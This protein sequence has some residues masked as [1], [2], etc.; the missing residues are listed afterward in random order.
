MLSKVASTKEGAKAAIWK[1]VYIAEAHAIDEWPVRSARFNHGH[2][3]VLV[4]QP[5]R[6][7]ERCDLARN[8]ANDF[9]GTHVEDVLVDDPEL[10]DPFEK[11]YAPWPLRLYLVEK[12]EMRWIAEPRDCSFDDAVSHLMKLLKLD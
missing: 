5:V 7:E 2:G 11:A 1:F 4:Q 6:H 12:G 9:L 10:G 8:F 3:P